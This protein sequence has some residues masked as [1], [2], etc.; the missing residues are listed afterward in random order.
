MLHQLKV[1]IP[2]FEFTVS[3]VK[4]FEVR[5]ND[6]V[7][8]PGDVLLL[9][10]WDQKKKNYTGRIIFRKVKYILQ[11]VFGL[12]DDLCVMQLGILTEEEIKRLK[13]GD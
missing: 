8:M 4:N 12:P 11:G 10:E 5:K 13:K 7:F 1:W 2:Y 9:S 6:R 3:G